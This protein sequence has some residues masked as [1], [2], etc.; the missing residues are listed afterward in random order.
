MGGSSS[1]AWEQFKARVDELGGEVLEPHWLGSAVGHRIRC[2]YGHEASPRPNAVQRGQ[3]ICRPCSGSD[4]KTAWEQ[5]RAGVEERGGEVVEPRWLGKDKRHRVICANGHPSRPRPGYV[6]RGGGICSVCSGNDPATAWV[7]FKAR[8]ADLGGK[9]IEPKWLGKATPHR[10]I[11]ANGHLFT[12][13]PNNIRAGT[14]RCLRCIGADPATCWAW[15]KA[16]VEEL[17]GTVL[18]PK[19]L[20]DGV[21]HRVICREGHD[22]TTIPSGVK[23]GQGICRRCRGMVWD[24]FYI[25]QDE[26]AGHV[27]FGI[28]SGDP[29]PRLRTHASNGFK[30]VKLL[31]EGLPGNFAHDLET[32]IRLALA[33]EGMK[34]VRGREYFEISATTLILAIAKEHLNQI[35]R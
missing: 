8:V 14:G 27:K 35:G 24:V 11:C 29:R 23:Q 31:E 1:G 34:P 15:F 6:Q 33:D 13:T 26:D 9:V 3:G 4:P 16:R 20:G 2:K 7:N 21:H 32:F 17:G 10:V 19:W 28:S 22:G 5:F 12:P 25:V 30:T 18:E